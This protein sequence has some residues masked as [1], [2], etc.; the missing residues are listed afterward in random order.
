MLLDVAILL[1]LGYGIWWWRSSGTKG[2]NPS[3]ESSPKPAAAAFIPGLETAPDP[4]ESYTR[5]EFVSH[6]GALHGA[7]DYQT[8]YTPKD[9]SYA[10]SAWDA[11]PT[12]DPASGASTDPT[13]DRTTL[14]IAW[15]SAAHDGRLTNDTRRLFE[16]ASRMMRFSAIAGDK[17]DPKKT[18]GT[19]DGSFAA[20]DASSGFELPSVAS[21]GAYEGLED[22][23]KSETYTRE[24]FVTQVDALLATP[25]VAHELT[26]MDTATGVTVSRAPTVR[27]SSVLIWDDGRT[28][29]RAAFAIDDYAAG[30][31]VE[32]VPDA[33]NT[34]VVWVKSGSP[35]SK[36]VPYSPEVAEQLVDL[37]MA[38]RWRAVSAA[39]SAEDAENTRAAIDEVFTRIDLVA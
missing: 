16:K 20:I 11:V 35:G 1:G 5:E 27:A 22:T 37:A 31:G 36:T 18:M 39:A 21:G 3:K 26:S 6:V 15:R 23:V 4:V 14:A 34:T 32:P 8:Y 9:S 28:A 33:S 19:I 25:E 38:M 24:K 29:A 10:V 17:V 12:V 13:I 2:A 7:A 30:R